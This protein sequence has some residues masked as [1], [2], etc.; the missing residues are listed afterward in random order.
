[1][2][3]SIISSCIRDLYFI[4]QILQLLKF[5]NI[6]IKMANNENEVDEVG[7]SNIDE[8]NSRRAG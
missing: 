3:H 1:M 2:E 7:V 8:I 4:L 5:N 6:F